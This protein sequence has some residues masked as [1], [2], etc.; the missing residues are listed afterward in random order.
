MQASYSDT[1][2][3]AMTILHS[4]GNEKVAYGILGCAA[5]VA[6]LSN[7]DRVLSPKEEI[8]FIQSLME[9]NEAYWGVDMTKEM[10]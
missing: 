8:T 7:P 2:N 1:N 4:L 9:W 5:V 3:V 6:R 10:N